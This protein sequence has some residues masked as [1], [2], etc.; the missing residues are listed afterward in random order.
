MNLSSEQHLPLG[1]RANLTLEGQEQLV[2][3]LFEDHGPL[4]DDLATGMAADE[5]IYFRIDGTMP[6]SQGRR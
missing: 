1:V 2:S 6:L 3:L 4:I 5:T